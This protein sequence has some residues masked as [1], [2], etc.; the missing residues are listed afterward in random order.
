MSEYA[1]LGLVAVLAVVLV[2]L[3]LWPGRRN[4]E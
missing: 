2:V 4:G 1:A 3:M